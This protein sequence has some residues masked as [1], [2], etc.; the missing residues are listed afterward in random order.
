MNNIKLPFELTFFELLTVLSTLSVGYLLIYKFSFYYYLGIPWFTTSLTPSY[1]I[2]SSIG[3]MILSIFGLLIG[4]AISN[5]FSSKKL[6]ILLFISMF[7]ICIFLETYFKNNYAEIY[8]QLSTFV[9]FTL[10][11]IMLFSLRNVYKIRM[12]SSISDSSKITEKKLVI[13]LSASISIFMYG[14]FPFKFGAEEAK[15]IIENKGDLTTIATLKDS[16]EK[17]FLI[18]YSNDKVLLMRSNNQFKLVEYKDLDTI[19]K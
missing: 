2:F 9:L 4:Y 5:V 14:A 10:Y 1:I 18:E 6:V 16:K 11:S 17:W 15:N 8:R 13:F 19:T 7:A 12:N 3:V